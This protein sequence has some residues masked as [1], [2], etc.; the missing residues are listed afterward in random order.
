[1]SV[2]PAGPL[3]TRLLLL[4][5][6]AL[7]W[8]RGAGGDPPLTSEGVRDAEVAAAALPHFDVIVSSPQRAGQETVEAVLAQRPVA[9]VWR[10]ALDEIRSAAFPENADAY[11]AWLDRLFETYAL[12]DQ[13][14]SL[15]DGVERLTAALRAIADQHYGRS[16]LIISHPVILLAFRGHL[17]QTAVQRDQV[18]ALPPLA[19]SIIDYLEG[20]FYLVQDFPT[21][22]LP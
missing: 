1:M 7:D 9:V 11:S 8:T 2:M 16:A 22:Y 12:S 4:C 19:L 5:R 13:G 17:M 20:R 21:R 14:E 3:R 18:D 10:D 15:A 6:G